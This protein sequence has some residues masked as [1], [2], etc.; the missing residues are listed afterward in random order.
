MQDITALLGSLIPGVL[1]I[2]LATVWL[3]FAWLRHRLEEHVVTD[4]RVISRWGILRRDVFAYPL[5]GIQSID[6]RQG[7]LARLFGYGT[8]GI[9]T[10]AETHGATGRR[11]I[12]DPER[13]RTQIQ[14]AMENSQGDTQG[15]WQEEN[16]DPAGRL[17]ELESLLNEG[18]INKV[19]YNQK[20]REILNEL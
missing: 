1:L 10:S 8:V 9:H 12:Q 6:V 2:A 19:E 11:Y 5:E 15:N 16:N 20:R 17:R 3:G 18:L 13:W 4:R 14:E 7:L